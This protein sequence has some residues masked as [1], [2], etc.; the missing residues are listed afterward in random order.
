MKTPAILLVEDNAQDEALFLR[1]IKR[2]G[3]QCNVIVLRDGQQALDYLFATGDFAPNLTTELPAI[4]V[5]DIGLP[6]LSGID[7]LKRLRTTIRTSALRIIM[8]SSSD[9]E[10]DRI[11][12]F[13]NGADGYV[14]KPINFH[15]YNNAVRGML[16]YWLCQCQSDELHCHNGGPGHPCCNSR[17]PYR[18][19]PS[20]YE[21]A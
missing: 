12:G 1:A 5:L 17:T 16:E 13:R 6:R 10:S 3:R 4:V 20:Q 18:P 15:E 2:L 19:D 7:V 8:F 21:G 9:V 11:A 14:V